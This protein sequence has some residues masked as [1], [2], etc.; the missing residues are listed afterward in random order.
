MPKLRFIIIFVSTQELA[1][2]AELFNPLNR[3]VSIRAG[4][5]I[6]DNSIDL[7]GFLR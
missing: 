6:V 3:Q 4:F 2:L 5:F 1:L 7:I